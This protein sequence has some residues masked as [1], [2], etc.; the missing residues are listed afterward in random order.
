MRV[1]GTNAFAAGRRVSLLATRVV[2][3]ANAGFY[4]SSYD[5]DLPTD[6]DDEYW[7]NGD[8]VQP[9]GKPSKVSAFIQWIKLHGIVAYALK[10]VVRPAAQQ[11]LI[12]R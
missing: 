2:D 11:Q 7:E 8:F 6:V 1:Y 3:F 4:A 9:P 5:A 12:R 10:T